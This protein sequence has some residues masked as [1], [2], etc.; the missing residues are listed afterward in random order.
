MDSGLTFAKSQKLSPGIAL[1][2]AQMASLTSDIVW[3]EQQTFTLPDGS[4]T[5][6][7]VPHVYA[8]IRPGDLAPS[9]ALLGGNSV[10]INAGGDVN[11][12]G[13]IAGRMLVQI[14]ANNVNNALG[15][16]DGQRRQSLLV[17]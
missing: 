15:N 8:A 5:Q 10:A 17:Q 2:A 6:A 1:S 3:L 12:S 9:G 7:I 13:T 14:S 4:T 11:N 16:I